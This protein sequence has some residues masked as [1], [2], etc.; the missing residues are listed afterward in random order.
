MFLTIEPT[1]GLANRL[2]TLD[3]AIALG[4]RSQLPTRLRWN[5]NADLGG[6]FQRFFEL[7]AELAALENVEA[8]DARR[9]LPR[10]LGVGRRRAYRYLDDARIQRLVQAGADFEAFTR[11]RRPLY[12]R[13]CYRFFPN[14]NAYA[15]LAPT[16]RLLASI[17][18]YAGGFSDHTIGVHVR[19]TDHV[20]SRERSPDQLFF[21]AL[22]AA[23]VEDARSVFCLCTDDFETLHRFRERYGE[24]IISRERQQ[25]GRDSIAAI[26]DAVIDLFSLARCQRILGSE[27]S[28][29]SRL[30]AQV[31]GIER[32]VLSLGETRDTPA[33]WGPLV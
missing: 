11:G 20:V 2:R 7:P 30:A 33:L 17:D 32:R 6:A 25:F 15:W 22:D 13:T 4:S 23:I 9:I 21:A 28:S 8:S 27:W 19:R 16:A 3:A 14:P 5:V 24:R 12:I 31:G 18:A 1:G 10:L 26:E 29:F